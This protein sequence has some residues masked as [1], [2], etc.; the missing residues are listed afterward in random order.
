MIEMAN[1]SII[2]TK[3]KGEL[4][5]PALDSKKVLENCEK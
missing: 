3:G 2:R 5:L 1:K 4:G